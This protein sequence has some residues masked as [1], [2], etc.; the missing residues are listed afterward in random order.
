MEGDHTHWGSRRF[1][2]G[3]TPSMEDIEYVSSEKH[4]SV[5]T[6]PTFIFSTSDDAWFLFK[7]VSLIIWLTPKGIPAELHIFEHGA[8][9]KRTFK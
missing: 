8:H 2:L 9:G 1:L 7:I 5:A 4:V 3:P 6:L